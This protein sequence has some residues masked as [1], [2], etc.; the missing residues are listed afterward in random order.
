MNQPNERVDHLM[1][2]LFSMAPALR[3]ECGRLLGEVWARHARFMPSRIGKGDPPRTRVRD[4]PSQL[5][6]LVA[7]QV[8]DVDARLMFAS[9]DRD[10]YPYFRL[11]ADPLRGHPPRQP[12][13]THLE[14]DAVCGP[15]EMVALFVDVA[16]LVDPYFGFLTTQAHNWQELRF[17]SRRADRDPDPSARA[18]MEGGGPHSYH[19]VCVPDVFW[20]Q[21]YGPAYLNRWGADALDGVG[22]RQHRLTNGGLVVWTTDTP[23]FEPEATAPEQVSWKSDLYTA[24]GPERFARDD[25]PWGGFG[26]RVP[27]MTEHA[28][29]V[30][31]WPDVRSLR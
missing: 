27:L 30:V 11:V 19:E 12:W 20:V 22:V 14:W 9:P 8:G 4:L 17:A 23:R 25:Q 26:E 7:R 24:V 28:A 31:G 21:V 16:E 1:A 3:P 29:A 13:P 5:E 10:E 18:A 2:E 6:E 15:E